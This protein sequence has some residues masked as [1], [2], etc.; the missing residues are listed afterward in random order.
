[1]KRLFLMSMI[2]C[3]AIFY[4]SCKKDG[5]APAKTANSYQSTKLATSSDS[6]GVSGGQDGPT[7]P[8]N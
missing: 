8:P 4:T 1:M 2:A 5:I 6:T 3:V 7:L